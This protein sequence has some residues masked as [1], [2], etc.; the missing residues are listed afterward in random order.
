MATQNSIENNNDIVIGNGMYPDYDS[1]TGKWVLY[2]CYTHCTCEVK[3]VNLTSFH[4]FLSFFP[5]LL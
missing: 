3:T 1:D 5:F 4:D 2:G